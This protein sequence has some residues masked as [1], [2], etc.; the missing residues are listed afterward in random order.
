M[1]WLG[2]SAR[3]VLS[4]ILIFQLSVGQTLAAAGDGSTGKANTYSI[5][6]QY[7]LKLISTSEQVESGEFFKQDIKN[8]DI[9]Q[10]TGQ[11]IEIYNKNGGIIN[12]FSLD[13]HRVEKPVISITNLRPRYN[14]KTRELVFEGKRGAQPDGSGGLLVARHIIPNVDLVAM[15]R[16]A[17]M[18]IFVDS[19]GR[20][21]AIDMGYVITQVFSTPIPIFKNLWSPSKDLT[22]TS[23]NTRAQFLT[24]GVEP[25]RSE[26]NPAESVVP[27]DKNGNVDYQ[28]GDL[29]VRYYEGQTE[30]VLGSFSRQVTADF[31][32]QGW[33]FIAAL[34]SVISP[35]KE[36]LDFYKQNENRI[37][38][39]I[40]ER[41]D[42]IY[43]QSQKFLSP[44]DHIGI[45]QLKNLASRIDALEGVKT[46][47]N[48]RFTY[49]EWRE[50]YNKIKE[51]ASDAQKLEFLARQASEL[52]ENAV[53]EERKA[54]YRQLYTKWLADAEAQQRLNTPEGHARGW[55]AT[56]ELAPRDNP[57]S[58]KGEKP[59]KLIS[60]RAAEW[61]IIGTSVAA[62]TAYLAGA[63]AYT[64]FEVLQQF[65]VLTFI[66]EHMYPDVMK[67][68]IY[69]I[70]LSQH[71]FAW[72][73]LIPGII[74]SSYLFGRTL[75]VIAKAYKNSNTA[76]GAFIRDTQRVWGSSMAD[77]QRVTS[78]GLRAYSYLVYPYLREIIEKTLRQRAFLSAYEHGINPFRRINRNS[79]VGKALGLE[80]SEFVG[81]SNP[82]AEM[83]PLDYAKRAVDPTGVFI[84]NNEAVNT[85]ERK[86]R[87]QSALEQQN[88]RLQSLA[89]MLATLVVSN[90]SGI[91]PATLLQV[92]E[93]RATPEDLRAIFNDPK[94][95]RE[96][97]LLS[98]EI[99]KDLRSRNAL[100]IRQEVSSLSPE[101]IAEF[102]AA[103]QEAADKISKQSEFRQNVALRWKKVKSAPMNAFNF[104]FLQNGRS[105]ALFLR[106]LVADRFVSNQ[107]N[108]EFRYDHLMVVLVSAFI[109]K[110][111]DLS[112]PS[113]LS[114]EAGGF[115][116]TSHE[117]N[118]DMVMNTFAHFFVSGASL[119]LVFQKLRALEETRYM[120]KETLTYT[121]DPRKE[122]L[123]RGIGNWLSFGYGEREKDFGRDD[124]AERTNLFQKGV[125]YAYNFGTQGDI[126]G[127][128]VKRVF[129]R[130]NTIQ[131][132][133]SLAVTFRTIIGGQ[134]FVT[135]M[136]AWA[137]MFMAGHWF[138]GWIWDPIQRGNQMI[139]ERI[140]RNDR[141][142][143][144][145]KF[146]IHRGLKEN[147]IELVQKG[148]DE[149]RALYEK[150][151]PKVIQQLKA[152]AETE[153]NNQLREA[154][155]ERATVEPSSQNEFL[156]IYAKLAAAKK[157]GNEA[158]FKRGIELLRKTLIEKQGYDRAEVA[159]LNAQ[160]I[161]EF[162]LSNAPVYTHP[163]KFLSD[164]FTITGGFATTVMYLP[165]SIML[166]DPNALAPLNLTKWA[167][168]STGL[169]F[170]AWAAFGRTPWLFYEKVYKN[171]AARFEAKRATLVNSTS[172]NRTSRAE[173][174]QRAAT[175]P[176][177]SI[178]RTCS[179]LFAN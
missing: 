40:R 14:S 53:T 101:K 39:I 158:E 73:A 112:N 68:M 131:A 84:L 121:S 13:D 163:N 104:L 55:Q 160:S 109:G 23:E 48:D 137:L 25:T 57:L 83:K 35:D 142:F 174:T 80:R 162:S 45:E 77:F 79:E 103:A 122:G 107:V 146:K 139:E 92:S 106:S 4:T 118:Y 127:I 67:D 108:Q 126:G 100:S 114:A 87:I 72:V 124:R 159:K 178:T 52:S 140:S 50:E 2:F 26:I 149:M 154:Y 11:R 145:A 123:L 42:A 34:R 44:I 132:G 147:D 33:A 175:R 98:S 88:V 130:L 41:A 111:A 110:R 120:P 116:W 168:I 165:L 117:H 17:E 6:D 173:A 30:K 5:H 179:Q 95:Q 9:F 177:Q 24:R 21:H 27:L 69:R 78:A 157:A 7:V 85:T 128:M 138:Y 89:W 32:K 63:F 10:L 152:I 28:A 43:E 171:V 164:I 86:Q 65:Q 148:Y 59:A 38:D 113:K 74:S 58:S 70:P 102:Y 51:T 93:T 99:E 105:D 20:L 81:L 167:F 31:M 47:P 46:R 135:A 153:F 90:K 143:E 155:G 56:L 15:D 8:F 18:L 119:A 36:I 156:G 75:D 71:V 96:W 3:L 151:N 1:K 150:H 12:S 176:S 141:E 62:V 170:A 172:P 61:R 49:E 91:D 125:N 16:D 115:M 97:E 29:L 94:K 19:K 169:Y 129:K 133:L 76:F 82:F 22:L 166:F 64:G 144:A 37:E 60:E 54:L 161:L 134:D 136:S 66:Y